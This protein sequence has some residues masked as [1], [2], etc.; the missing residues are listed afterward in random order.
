MAEFSGVSI[1]SALAIKSED[2]GS[3]TRK[4]LTDLYDKIRVF[5]NEIKKLNEEQEK[6]KNEKIILMKELE[7]NN[8]LT[9]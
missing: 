1:I 9:K 5:E 4:N 8:N 2:L 3:S 7:E 6:I